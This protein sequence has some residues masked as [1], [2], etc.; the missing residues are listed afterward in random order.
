MFNEELLNYRCRRKHPVND[1]N[2]F[3][4]NLN[5]QIRIKILKY[6]NTNLS[7]TQNV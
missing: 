4:L 6:C 7:I 2:D 1:F 5:D 3:T